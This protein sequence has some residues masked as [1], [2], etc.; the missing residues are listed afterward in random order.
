LVDRYNALYGRV[1]GNVNTIMNNIEVNVGNS[2]QNNKPDIHE[3]LQKL[4]EL[5]DKGHLTEEEYNAQKT[6]LLR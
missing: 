6:R 1:G 5:K 4:A 2:K 3:Q